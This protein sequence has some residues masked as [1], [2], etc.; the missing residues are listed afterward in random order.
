MAYHCLAISMYDWTYCPGWEASSTAAIVT[1]PNQLMELPHLTTILLLLEERKQTANA[2]FMVTNLL[3]FRRASSS[4]YGQVWKV[5]F[6]QCLKE[7]RKS[8]VWK[9]LRRPNDHA[10]LNMHISRSRFMLEMRKSSCD[11]YPSKTLHQLLCTLL[12]TSIKTTVVHAVLLC[13]YCM[14]VYNIVCCM[15]IIL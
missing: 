7:L 6:D 4:R 10:T 14:Y 9:V 12:Q 13:C 1:M 5:G 8:R 11:L 3:R 15:Q 2:L